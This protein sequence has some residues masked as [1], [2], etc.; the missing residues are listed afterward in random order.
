MVP[1][2]SPTDFDSEPAMA[3]VIRRG[4]R[5]CQR[6]RSSRLANVGEHRSKAAALFSTGALPLEAV[7]RHLN[8]AVSDFRLTRARH[9]PNGANDYERYLEPYKA[10]AVA[11]PG[12]Q[13]DRCAIRTREARQSSAPRLVAILRAARAFPVSIPRPVT[14]AGERRR[15]L[16]APTLASAGNQRWDCALMKANAPRERGVPMR[17]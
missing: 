15:L 12:G 8:D 10:R 7:S 4:L 1:L 14:S 5:F 16:Q 2:S 6:S 9:I 13:G 11:Q 3:Q 17:S